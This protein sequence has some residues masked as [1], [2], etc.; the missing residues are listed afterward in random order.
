MIFLII[1]L[2]LTNPAA[3]VSH[4]S[5]SLYSVGLLWGVGMRVI[6]RFVL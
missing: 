3:S 6:V 2:P 4:S 1:T 5:A